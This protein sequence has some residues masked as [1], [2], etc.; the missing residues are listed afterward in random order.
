[1]KE[2]FPTQTQIFQLRRIIYHHHGPAC[3]TTNSIFHQA[4]KIPYNTRHPGKPA[5]S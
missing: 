3:Q 2:I 4:Q 5:C 1:M